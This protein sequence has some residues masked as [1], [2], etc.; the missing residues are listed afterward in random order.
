MEKNPWRRVW[1]LLPVILPGNPMD[2]MDRGTWH[3][4]VY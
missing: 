3:T 2:R 1:K 4:K